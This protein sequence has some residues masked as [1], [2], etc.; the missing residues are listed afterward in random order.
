M[1]QD[2]ISKIDSE[3]AGLQSDIEA[4]N[5][6]NQKKFGGGEHNLKVG[7]DLGVLCNIASK[8]QLQMEVERILVPGIKNYVHDAGSKGVIVGISGGI[9]SAVVATLAVRALGN[10]WVKGVYMPCQKDIYTQYSNEEDSD[11]QDAQELAN[12]LD[13]EFSVLDFTTPYTVFLHRINL[14]NGAR[15]G[16][17]GEISPE[18]RANLKARMRMAALYALK[19]DLNYLCIGTGNRTELMTGYLTKYGDGGVD[20]EPLGEYYK[21]E[22]KIL[23][24]IL[25]IKD[26]VP[27]IVNKA[28]SARLTPG[29]TDEDDL[30]M[31]YEELD[32]ILC[33]LSA[34]HGVAPK[35][36]W[37]EFDEK[38]VSKVLGMIDRSAHKRKSPPSIKRSH[39]DC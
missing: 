37:R 11:R 8:E 16:L 9:D 24:N 10:F 34:R 17:H 13:I 27:N 6:M 31:S 19:E 38:K 39:Y 29:Q 18:A 22:V 4:L 33:S 1:D 36:S 25:G 30:G 3:L 5:K 35:K 21:T 20:F 7:F 28:P 23:A 12:W 26:A 2:K 32:Q 14:A 15:T